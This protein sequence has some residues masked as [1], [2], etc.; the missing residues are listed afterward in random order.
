VRTTWRRELGS[1]HSDQPH[2]AEESSAKWT[3]VPLDPNKSIDELTIDI[4]YAL[5][6]MGAEV[7]AAG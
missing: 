2:D 7:D 1:S 3:L 6:T 4:L 5:E